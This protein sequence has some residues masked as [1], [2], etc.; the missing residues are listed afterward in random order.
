MNESDKCIIQEIVINETNKYKESLNFLKKIEMLYKLINNNMNEI[1][2]FFEKNENEHVIK[3]NKNI[4]K[5]EKEYN[6]I[7]NELYKFDVD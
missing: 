6:E 3:I 2:I 5:K 7:I 1:N 4:K